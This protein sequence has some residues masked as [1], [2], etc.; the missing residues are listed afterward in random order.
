MV[1]R[2]K[3]ALRRRRDLAKRLP[4]FRAH[5]RTHADVATC[6]SEYNSVAAGTIL[7]N[8]KLG[9]FT[10]VSANVRIGN[11]SLGAF[12]SV[13]PEAMI[14]G[15]G[16][17]PT[18]WLTTHPSFYSTLGQVGLHFAREDSYEELPYTLVGND[19]WIGA[20]AII[21][22]GLTVGDGAI[23][24]AGA[25]VAKDVPPYAIVGGVPAKIIRYRFRKDVIDAL[26]DWKWWE[27]ST[28]V[29][30][31]IASDFVSRKEWRAEDVQAIRQRV[32]WIEES[33]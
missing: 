26:V 17:H 12:C 18:Q 31:E 5:W 8:A 14:G 21:L 28:T 33:P 16:K 2:L 32:L 13:G 4:G 22:D 29:L 9:R 24:A 19:V 20:R 10:N 23:I 7:S 15:L 1:G 30:Q 3:W 6:F 11:C 27:L 25:V